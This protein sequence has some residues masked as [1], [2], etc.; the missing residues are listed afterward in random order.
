MKQK[1]Q[2]RLKMEIQK[3]QGREERLELEATGQK[4]TSYHSCLKVHGGVP[5]EVCIFWDPL[6]IRINCMVI[7]D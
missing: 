2:S 1:G 4:H 6:V 3:A 7:R 5:I